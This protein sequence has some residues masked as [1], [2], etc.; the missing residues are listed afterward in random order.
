[1]IR[2]KGDKF[3]LEV[4]TPKHTWKMLGIVITIHIPDAVD[5]FLV[6]FKKPDYHFYIKGLGF[7]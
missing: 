6:H 7:L 5:A 4:F 2:R 1:M 3:L